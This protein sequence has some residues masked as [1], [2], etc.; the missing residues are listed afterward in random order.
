MSS[1]VFI[2]FI[3]VVAFC[4]GYIVGAIFTKSKD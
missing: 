3:T 4:F 1:G 2:Y